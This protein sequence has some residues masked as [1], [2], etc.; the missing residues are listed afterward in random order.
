MKKIII[1]Q[2]ASSEL[3]SEF[4]ENNI[5]VAPYIAYLGTNNG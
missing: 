5:N 3:L 2:E 4:F 1:W